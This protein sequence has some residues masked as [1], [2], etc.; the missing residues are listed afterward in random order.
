[1]RPSVYLLSISGVNSELAGA[2][3]LNAFLVSDSVFFVQIFFLQQT[4]PTDLCI[5]HV[6]ASL[7]HGIS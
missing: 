6:P 4:Q 5:D 7:L 3:F 1:M 2:N